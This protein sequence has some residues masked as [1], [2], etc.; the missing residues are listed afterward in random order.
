MLMKKPYWGRAIG[1]SIT[2][3]A[4]GNGTAMGQFAGLGTASAS[5][6][7]DVGTGA[8]IDVKGG[9][10]TGD[11]VN[12]SVFVIQ[13]G[14]VGYV[15]GRTDGIVDL[16]VQIAA[17]DG[18]AISL[19]LFDYDA[20]GDLDV[21]R[22]ADLSGGELRMFRNDGSGGFALDFA[23]TGLG[24]LSQKFGVRLGDYD[25]DGDADAILLR[26]AGI[27]VIENLGNT[28]SLT[29]ISTDFPN[30]AGQALGAGDLNGDG[31]ADAAVLSSSLNEIVVIESRASGA[32]I[33]QR[34]PFANDPGEIRLVDI[35]QDGDLDA[36][37][38]TIANGRI[39]MYRNNGTGVLSFGYSLFVA[40]PREFEIA[41]MDADG[42]LDLVVLARGG[43][44]FTFADR[45]VVFLNDG[46]GFFG[47]FPDLY[48]MFFED[49]NTIS[50]HSVNPATG[51]DVVAAHH[52]FQGRVVLRENLTA[53][54]APSDFDLI[55]PLNQ[56]VNLPTP[57]A[58]AAWGGRTRPLAEWEPAGG[59]GVTY[60]LTFALD[61]NLSDVVTTISGLS[62]PS[63]DLS[64]VPLESGTT[65]WWGVRATNNAGQTLAS[66]GPFSFSTLG[67]CPADLNND[68]ALNF[69]DVSLFLQAFNA[70]CP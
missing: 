59:F 50:V 55:A 18:D 58:I 29:P 21:L 46:K 66:N 27:A 57:Q 60:E 30:F 2:G 40:G 35:D 20:D 45:V 43:P 62:V 38:S 54:V 26:D 68:G 12:D 67:G 15:P 22:T 51:P 5:P 36:I 63:A 31:R 23:I 48:N 53:A 34:I 52:V 4:L 65:Y 10:V 8:A 14:W 37:A 42:T 3:L 56:A 32:V 17:A 47:Q 69:F 64:S 49:F 16:P 1:A 33:T 70:G 6:E 61:E 9:D 24:T 39:D 7:F 11:G 44:G 28:F 19:A 41:D 25:A 13:N